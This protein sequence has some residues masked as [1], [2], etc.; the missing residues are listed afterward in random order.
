MVDH[1][2]CFF[3]ITLVA[4]DKWPAQGSKLWIKKEQRKWE[5]KWSKLMI[6]SDVFILRKGNRSLERLSD[7][8]VVAYLL[9]ISMLGLDQENAVKK[10]IHLPG[11]YLDSQTHLGCSCVDFTCTGF[12]RGSQNYL[13]ES[14]PVFSFAFDRCCPQNLNK[15]IM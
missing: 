4:E 8:L 10:L 11:I 14:P 9:E 6:Q 2:G 1:L 7:L 15:G 13:G 3:H 5:L 12:L